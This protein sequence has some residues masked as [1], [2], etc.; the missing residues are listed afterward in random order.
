[1]HRRTLTQA[2]DVIGR[3]VRVSTD[4]DAGRLVASLDLVIVRPQGGTPPEYLYGVLLEERFRQ[5]CRSRSSGTTVL[6]LSR[7]A[8]PQYEAPDIALEKQEGFASLA[9]PL[10][11]KQDALGRESARLVALRDAL[12][13]E[14]LS[15]R[16][17][18]PETVEA[19]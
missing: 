9:R 12:L 8:L 5:H 11:D 13:P 17:Q 14:L 3:V 2:A 10:L 18:V 19:S 1:M 4:V 6:H 16:I 15:G 7:D